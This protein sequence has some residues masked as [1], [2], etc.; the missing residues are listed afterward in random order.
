[1][2]SVFCH[3]CKSCVKKQNCWVWIPDNRS[4]PNVGW[5]RPHLFSGPPMSAFCILSPHLTTAHL[6]GVCASSLLVPGT[7]NSLRLS[8][9]G[10]TASGKGSAI[11][12]FTPQ[13]EPRVFL[14]FKSISYQKK[15]QTNKQTNFKNEGF[16]PYNMSFR[17][18]K[19][20]EEI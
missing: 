5:R 17:A 18:S 15:T 6:H 4:S 13:C 14:S 3:L 11:S 9:L 8:P 19:K 7:Q 1:M 20:M 12:H 2:N 16:V 10:K